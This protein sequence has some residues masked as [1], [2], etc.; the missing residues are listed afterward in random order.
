[1]IKTLE[2]ISTFKN[3]LDNVALVK[4]RQTGALEGPITLEHD[5][6][7]QTVDLSKSIISIGMGKGL[8]PM[9]LAQCLSDPSPYQVNGKSSQAPK[10]NGDS[11]ESTGGSN[12]KGVPAGGAPSKDSSSAAGGSSSSTPSKG[13]SAATSLQSLGVITLGGISAVA[14]YFLTL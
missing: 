10:S 2:I 9:N 3:A 14:S 6:T 7:L 5:L 13:K 12:S 11:A 1:M 8:K 4:S